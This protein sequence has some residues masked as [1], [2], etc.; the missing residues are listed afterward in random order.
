MVPTIS[1]TASIIDPSRGAGGLLTS[2]VYVT[3]RP[4]GTRLLPS[5]VPVV[6]TAPPANLLFDPPGLH[7]GSSILECESLPIIVRTPSGEEGGP[8][9]AGIG[10]DLL[11]LRFAGRAGQQVARASRGSPCT[12]CADRRTECNGYQTRWQRDEPGNSQ[13]AQGHPKIEVRPTTL[14]R[15]R[16]RPFENRKP[17]EPCGSRGFRRTKLIRIN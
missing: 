8:G 12:P 3:R 2:Q 17:R 6:G 15:A 5:H 10:G 13:Q 4:S 14:L 16:L 11:S 7:C 9:D 1:V